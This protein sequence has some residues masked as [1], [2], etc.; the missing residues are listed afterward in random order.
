MKHRVVLDYEL[1][2]GWLAPWI[3]G[4]RNGEAV[5][6]HCTACDSAW[7]PPLRACPGCRAR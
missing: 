6:S 2:E 7:F 4:L 3:E 5:A 1:A